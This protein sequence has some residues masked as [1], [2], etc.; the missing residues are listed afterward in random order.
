MVNPVISIIVPVYKVERFVRKCI[1]SI[2]N[3]TFK[4]IEIIL[5]DD[6]SPDNCGQICDDYAKTDKRIRVIHKQN[7]GLSD[8]RNAGI[9][10]ARGEYI[11]FV[12][13]DDYISPNMYKCLYELIEKNNADIAVCRSVL[14]NENEDARFENSGIGK[15]MDN[16]QAL[17][18]MI[19][20]RLFTVNAWNKLY[21]TALFKDIRYPVGMLY[22]DL[23]TTYKLIDKSTYVVYT[24]ARL[25]AYVQR[26]GSI[27]NKTG[28]N[29][30]VDKLT[31]ISEMLDY[32][33]KKDVACKNDIKTCIIR[34]LL[35]DLYKMSSRG[36][37]L[38][39]S[40]YLEGLQVLMKKNRK[41]FR[42]LSVKEHMVADLSLYMPQLLQFIYKRRRVY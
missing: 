39:N 14:V 27:M 23:A 32:F 20:K 3:Q 42:R 38:E 17:H 15:K 5:V 9:D 16:E 40:E 1:D 26:D 4:D 7:G 12:D 25:Y 6:G 33:N 36:T 34:Y 37:L 21:K 24:D 29:V 30:S 28:Y 8:A 11:A 19:C 2:L 41:L 35:N 10:I 22:E 13:S 31:I 18:E